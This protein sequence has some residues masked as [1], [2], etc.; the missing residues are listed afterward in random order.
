MSKIVRLDCKES[1]GII[2]FYSDNFENRFDVTD[3]NNLVV[4]IDD[5]RIRNCK[6]IIL[7]HEG[8]NFCLGGDLS[9]LLP[10]T[11]EKID[12]FSSLIIKAVM[13]IYQS[14]LTVIAAIDG[15]VHG[16]GVCLLFCCDL[17]VASTV[18]TFAIPEALAGI[19]PV[20]SY[21]GACMGLG[22]QKATELALFSNS[23]EAINNPAINKIVPQGQSFSVALEMTEKIN[24]DCAKY[25]KAMRS[26]F[27]REKWMSMLN[28]ASEYLPKVLLK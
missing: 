18:S 11:K 27:E 8:P 19:P 4:M 2:T 21:A 10:Y 13:S 20:L 15:N 25:V 24:P 7:T 22:V 23:I 17:I 16:G 26:H 28:T 9:S 3:L 6:Y 1:F 5:A 14:P 12:Y